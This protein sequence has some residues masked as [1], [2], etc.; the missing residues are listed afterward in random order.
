MHPSIVLFFCRR[1]LNLGP[2]TGRGDKMVI[3]KQSLQCSRALDKQTAL[4]LARVGHRQESYY[5]GRERGEQIFFVLTGRH[6]SGQ[7]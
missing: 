1:I 2:A 5:R 6:L 4:D 3:H 7:L